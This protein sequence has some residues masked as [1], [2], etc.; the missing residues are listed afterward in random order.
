MS[1]VYTVYVTVYH[2]IDN[3]E[4]DSP[5]EAEELATT[6]YIWDEHIKDSCIEVEENTYA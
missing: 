2:R 6:D 3:V 4:A 5:E 1:K